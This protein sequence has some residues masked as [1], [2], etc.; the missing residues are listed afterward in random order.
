[1][2]VLTRENAQVGM[3]ITLHG[4][5]DSTP[6]TIIRI[7]GQR[8]YIQ[9]DK[10]TRLT[11]PKFIPGGFSAYCTNNYEIK[12]DITPDPEGFQTCLYPKK[13]GTYYHHKKPITIGRNYF[14]DYN[15]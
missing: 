4:W 6:Y 3:G 8:I 9:E 11:D 2:E 10:A 1:M 15:F 14:Y 5:S 7:S 13:N 12:Y